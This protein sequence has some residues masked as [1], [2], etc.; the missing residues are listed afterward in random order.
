ML[1]LWFILVEYNLSKDEVFFPK[2]GWCNNSSV[3]KIFSSEIALMFFSFQH[4]KIVNFDQCIRLPGFPNAV[5]TLVY[6][7]DTAR[8]KMMAHGFLLATQEDFVGSAR[9]S[10]EVVEYLPS[11]ITNV[12]SSLCHSYPLFIS[13]IS[14][15]LHLP[16]TCLF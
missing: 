1:I 8:E 2:L 9:L 3:I 15:E 5:R 14:K 4:L 7:E 11:H 16:K 13:G 6:L 12:F 10:L